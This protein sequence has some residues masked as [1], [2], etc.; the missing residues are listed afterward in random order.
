MLVTRSEP[1]GGVVAASRLVVMSWNDAVLHNEYSDA[2]S[3]PGSGLPAMPRASLM[4]PQN[5]GHTAA[6]Q[7]VS[8]ACHSRCRHRLQHPRRGQQPTYIHPQPRSP[9]APNNYPSDHTPP[10]AGGGECFTNGMLTSR[11]VPFGYGCAR[12]SVFRPHT[13]SVLRRAPALAAR[14]SRGRDK[15][16]P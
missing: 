10:R 3:I 13:V 2:L 14:P 8:P 6:A 4:R 12:R 7:L 11:R 16:D 1:G 9:R 15:T 5:A